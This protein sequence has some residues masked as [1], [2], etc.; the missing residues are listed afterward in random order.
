MDQPKRRSEERGILLLD[1]MST[2]RYDLWI[3]SNM[4]FDMA[5]FR[6]FQ[7]KRAIAFVRS[8]ECNT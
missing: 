2:S 8:T 7:P 6:L 4:V 1:D 5:H 3:R